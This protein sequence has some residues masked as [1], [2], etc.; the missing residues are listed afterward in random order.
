MSF[1]SMCKS[2]QAYR[3]NTMQACEN[4]RSQALAWLEETLRPLEEIGFTVARQGDRLHWQFVARHP[5]L[6]ID[7]LFRAI[8]TSGDPMQVTV[9]N[10]FSS[11]GSVKLFGVRDHEAT[12]VHV[13][14]YLAKCAAELGLLEDLE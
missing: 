9:S 11:S 12:R 6:S 14:A 13:Q 8:I 3:R 2:A 7:W 4:N 1:L 10:L 5:D